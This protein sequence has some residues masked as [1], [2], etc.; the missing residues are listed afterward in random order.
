[1]PTTTCPTDIG[2]YHRQI[3]LPGIGEEGQKKLGAARV[4]I[5]GAGGLGS[6]AGLY[7]A[8]AGVGTL[9]IAEF[10]RVEESNLHRQILYDYKDIG[11]LKLDRACQRLQAIDPKLNL[12]R[13]P[14]GI[15]LDNALDI[16]HHYDVVIDG[17]DNFPTRYLV[18]DATV[19]AKKPLVYGSIS[20]FEGQV[21]LF[22]ANQN[23]PC[24][25]CLFPEMPEPGSIPNCAEA[26][27]LGALCGVVGSLQAMEALKYLLGLGQTLATKLLTINALTMEFRSLAIKRDPECP[28][29]AN[30]PCFNDL[31]PANYIHPHSNLSCQT[32][33]TTNAMNDSPIEIDVEQAKAWL[34]SEQPPLLVD[35]RED[36]EVAICQIPES[37]HLPLGS[38]GERWQELPR[39]RQLLV[40]CHHGQRSLRATRFLRD[41]GLDQVTSLAG[42][43]HQWA[44]K[45]APDMN[46]Y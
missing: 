17:S 13:H 18:N 46:R 20:Q 8:T 38:L 44:L 4:L 26:G 40:Y 23:C 41:R 36:N 5:I 25:R 10:D 16:L 12:E 14:K 34:E 35:V 9:G 43:I 3:I 32:S 6:A 1:M 15:Q 7:L 45:W 28:I 42:G 39:D 21:S 29:C 2:R 27:V 22:S 30:Q 37:I 31:N 11:Q 24:Y 33:S 19:L